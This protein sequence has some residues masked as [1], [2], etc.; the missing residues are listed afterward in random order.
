MQ[1]SAYPAVKLLET[2]LYLGRSKT[3]EPNSQFWIKV[4]F[5]EAFN[6]A[7]SSTVKTL[8]KTAL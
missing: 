7:A 2:V 3:I 1:V 8:Y 5:D 6:T 4:F